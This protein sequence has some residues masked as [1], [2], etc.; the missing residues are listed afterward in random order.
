MIIIKNTMS[1]DQYIT[2]QTITKSYGVSSTTLRNWAENG[3]IKYIQHLGGR[4]LYDV[5]KIFQ[6]T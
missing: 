2:S 1:S 6:Q 4:R 3:I 5:L